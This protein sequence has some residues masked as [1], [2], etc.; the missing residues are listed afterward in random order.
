[1]KTNPS[2]FSFGTWH[3][4]YRR[5]IAEGQFGDPIFLSKAEN[6]PEGL[7]WEYASGKSDRAKY[8]RELI[9]KAE[10]SYKK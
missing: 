5:N 6:E 2:I 7:S 8:L 9:R 10:G 3:I 1:M 4:F